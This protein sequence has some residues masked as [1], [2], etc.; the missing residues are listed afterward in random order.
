MQLRSEQLDSHLGRG[1]GPI[2]VI[3]GDEPLI[4]LEA[5]DA[6]RAAARARGFTDREVFEPGRSFDWSEL[7]HSLASLS[8]FGGKKIVEVSADGSGGHGPS[9]GRGIVTG[10]PA[11][12]NAAPPILAVAALAG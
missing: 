6:V 2:Y 9:R 1:L 7:A 12:V 5:A 11:R 4:A 8:L 3:H 10:R